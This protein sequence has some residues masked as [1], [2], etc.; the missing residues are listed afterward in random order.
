MEV[1]MRVIGEDGNEREICGIER[2]D[3]NDMSDPCPECGGRE[4]NQISTS[5]GHYG[6]RNTAIVMRSDF[7]GVEQSLFTRCRDCR[8][9]LYKHPAFDLLFDFGEDSTKTLDR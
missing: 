7:W 5:G 3:W 2:D 6:P 9:I 8:E 1:T 4:F